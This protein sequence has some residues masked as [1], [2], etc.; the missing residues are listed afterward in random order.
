[1]TLT[2]RGARLLAL[3][4]V[5]AVLTA[6][7]SSGGDG[8]TADEL[9]QWA[10]PE[11]VAGFER[12][13]LERDDETLTIIAN[14]TLVEPPTLVTIFVYPAPKVVSVGSDAETRAAAELLLTEQEFRGSQ[15]A[16]VTSNPVASLLWED[17]QSILPML[18]VEQVGFAAGYGYRGSGPQ[19]VVDVGTGLLLFRH[20]D[21]SVKYRITYDLADEQA[22][23][24]KARELMGAVT[25]PEFD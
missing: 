8:A 24:T 13:P 11:A 12:Q 3:C 15:D 17:T 9:D 2:Q 10:F 18:G 7:S 6:C 1:M 23:A 16:L 25:W 19:G 20:G 4:G 21:W 5:A 22:A 14:Y